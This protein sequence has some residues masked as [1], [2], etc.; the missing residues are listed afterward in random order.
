MFALPSRTSVDRAP[1]IGTASGPRA[2]ERRL[3]VD[4]H[5]AAYVEFLIAFFPILLLFVGLLQLQLANLTQLFVTR[6]A[7]AAAR[8][9]AVY[10]PQPDDQGHVSH[11]ISA[12][13]RAAI[14]DAVLLAVAP[15]ML[16]GWL[17]ELPLVT[18]PASNDPSATTQR[19]SF[20]DG[21]DMVRVRL[22]ATYVC[23]L[24]P[25]DFFMCRAAGGRRLLL[26][27][28]EATFPYQRASYQYD[29]EQDP[30][31]KRPDRA[32]R[33]RGPRP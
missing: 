28:A 27:S 17:G 5:G 2:R 1:P 6:A 23:H 21:P 4:C 3:L 19:T 11:E 15:V 29:A 9:A 30:K 12:Q 20:A 7:F 22:L 24:P 26:L 13:A 8:A 32:P 10:I 14:D 18:L 33:G 31:Q 25:V 16:R